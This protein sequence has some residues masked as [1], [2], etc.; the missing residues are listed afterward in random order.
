MI[1]IA[2]TCFLICKCIFINF[3]KLVWKKQCNLVAT[4]QA[5][6]GMTPVTLFL[7]NNADD[8][9]EIGRELILQGVALPMFQLD[10]NT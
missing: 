8:D 7:C 6:F 1:P 5:C 3:Q 4:D 9:M 10:Q 2:S